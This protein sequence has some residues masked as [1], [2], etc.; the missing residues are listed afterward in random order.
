M[1]T[2]LLKKI[3]ESKAF[4]KDYMNVFFEGNQLVGNLTIGAGE[5][6]ELLN[7]MFPKSHYS[8]AYENGQSTFVTIFTKEFYY[9]LH[10]VEPNKSN[11]FD[12]NNLGYSSYSE[13]HVIGK[14]KHNVM[15]EEIST[16]FTIIVDNKVAGFFDIKLRLETETGQAT[17]NLHL[18]KIYVK[19]EYRG[20][21][22]WM[23]LTISVNWF[24]GNVLD[25]LAQKL[26]KPHYLDVYV[27]AEFHSAAGEKIGV[28][29]EREL[30]AIYESLPELLINRPAFIGQVYA[31]MG[32]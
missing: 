29:I 3:I 20:S 30:R 7:N 14:D 1:T 16:I 4:K 12:I 22:Y 24:V 26:K 2:P 23:D 5:R 28:I 18:N 21:T 8:K 15:M 31:E 10:G 27:Q 13:E 9:K 6:A 25:E 17:L 11:T 32:Y 19:P